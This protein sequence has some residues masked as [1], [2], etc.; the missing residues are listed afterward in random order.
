MPWSDYDS[1][2]CSIARTAQLLGD[3]W[4]VLVVRDLFNG[5]R[6]FDELQSH[7]GIARD[8]LTK[9]LALLVDEDLVE[10]RAYRVD[11]ERARHEYVLTQAGRELRTVLV[12]LMDWGD[13]HRAGAAGPPVSLRH[14][15]CG[16]EIHTHLVCDEGH[17]IEPSTRA[18]LIPLAG[19]RLRDVG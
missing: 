2:T 5:V 19:A 1:S 11:G 13:H 7:L 15:D 8:I 6:R 18:E 16:A 14:K 17:A 3:R 4:T 9:R 12:A 10:R